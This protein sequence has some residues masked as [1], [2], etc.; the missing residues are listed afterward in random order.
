MLSIYCDSHMMSLMNEPMTFNA[1]KCISDN[2]HDSLF[3]IVFLID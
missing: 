2:I 3:V 1:R